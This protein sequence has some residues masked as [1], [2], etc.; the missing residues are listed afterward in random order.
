MIMRA[1]VAAGWIDEASLAEE[2]E[3]SEE[4]LEG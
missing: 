1:R 4:A 3:E 2:A